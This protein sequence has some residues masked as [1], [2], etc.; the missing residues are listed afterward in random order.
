MGDRKVRKLV[1]LVGLLCC[2]LLIVAEEIVG[3]EFLGEALLG[4]FCIVL[5][6]TSATEEGKSGAEA[7]AEDM[8]AARRLARPS[9]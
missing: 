5:L 9:F 6:G 4:L 1:G 2:V 8:E 3:V 7:P